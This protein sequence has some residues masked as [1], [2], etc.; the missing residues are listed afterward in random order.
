M[1][2]VCLLSAPVDRKHRNISRAGPHLQ[3]HLSSCGMQ[4]PAVEGCAGGIQCTVLVE[5]DYVQ[6]QA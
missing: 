2:H 3:L 5:L 1:T 6:L 4:V